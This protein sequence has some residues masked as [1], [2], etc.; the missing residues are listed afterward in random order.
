MCDGSNIEEGDIQEKSTSF[1]IL[2]SD[3]KAHDN[4][5]A[6]LF[7]SKTSSS[8]PVFTSHGLLVD[9]VKITHVLSYYTVYTQSTIGVAQTM[10]NF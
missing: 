8:D 1:F 5:P 3:S 9:S 4:F 2:V 6:S 7:L 10:S